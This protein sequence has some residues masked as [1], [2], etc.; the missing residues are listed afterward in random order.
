MR[1]KKA[2][3]ASKFDETEHHD[4]A[5]S[6]TQ[7]VISELVWRI[8]EIG[9]GGILIVTNQAEHDTLFYKYRAVDPNCWTTFWLD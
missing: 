7:L 8:S 1:Q 3:E 6:K 5:D 4:S 2:Q 9:I